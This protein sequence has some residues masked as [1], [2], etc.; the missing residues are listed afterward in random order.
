M[1][2]V[3]LS[4]SFRKSIGYKV[5]RNPDA[6]ADAE[7]EQQE[8]QARIDDS[9]PLDD[10]ELAEKEELLSQV[11]NPL[12]FITSAF[13]RRFTN[14]WSGTQLGLAYI[15]AHNRL[16]IRIATISVLRYA[17]T[18]FLASLTEFV[19]VYWSP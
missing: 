14:F 11:S 6:G 16:H 5:P 3:N 2:Q 17:G 8:E 18:I 1:N 15:G 7:R 13:A 12:K 19:F 4:L 10:A 9:A